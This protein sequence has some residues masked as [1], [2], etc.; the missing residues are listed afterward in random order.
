MTAEQRE[1]RELVAR[2]RRARRIKF[3]KT[4]H[5]LACPPRHG[6]YLIYN[7]RGRVAHV[8]R[9]LRAQNG[10]LNRL[11]N[12]LHGQSSFVE[13][14]LKKRYRRLRH[15]YSYAWIEVRSPRRRALV[16]ALATGLICPRHIGTGATAS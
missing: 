13:L 8:G 9:T 3:P 16:E 2:L 11:R 4:G 1:V 7:Q 14:H 6:V 10:L 5:A 12:H 15:G